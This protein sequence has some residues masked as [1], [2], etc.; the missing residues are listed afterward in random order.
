VV[1][2][3]WCRCSI[4]GHILLFWLQVLGALSPWFES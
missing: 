1:L 3:W 4:P 2:G